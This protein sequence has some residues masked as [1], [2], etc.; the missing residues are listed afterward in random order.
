MQGTCQAINP[1]E[2]N[3]LAS[4]IG[5]LDRSAWGTSPNATGD[6]AQRCRRNAPHQVEKVA[7]LA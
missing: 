2:I 7:P 6:P 4:G 5:T 1:F 3:G